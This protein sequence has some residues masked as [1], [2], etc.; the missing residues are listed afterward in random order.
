MVLEGVSISFFLSTQYLC[1]P[2]LKPRTQCVL[3]LKQTLHKAPHISSTP[4]FTC[5]WAPSKREQSV[6]CLHSERDSP[7]TWPP[8]EPLVTFQFANTYGHSRSASLRGRH[9]AIP[10]SFGPSSTHHNLILIMSYNVCVSERGGYE[11]FLFILS[12]EL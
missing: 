8:S 1:L 12:N 6:A 4:T 3:P 7:S 2:C 5:R 11:Y 10:S 9:Q